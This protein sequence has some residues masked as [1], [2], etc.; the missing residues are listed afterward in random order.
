MILHS[1]ISQ[2]PES[3]R[4]VG[5]AL[6]LVLAAGSLDIAFP[7]PPASKAREPVVSSWLEEKV[8][9]STRVQET[10]SKP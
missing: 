5:E 7:V 10:V 9:H 1:E 4:H 8:R 6:G 3:V 2:R